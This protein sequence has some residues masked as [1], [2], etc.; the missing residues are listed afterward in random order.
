ML[1]VTGDARL[2]SITEFEVGDDPMVVRMSV[3]G[4]EYDFT[5]VSVSVVDDGA[6]GTFTASS[7]DGVSV[8]GAFRCS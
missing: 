4:V 6:A 7:V 1:R 5:D 2:G 3:N 8:D